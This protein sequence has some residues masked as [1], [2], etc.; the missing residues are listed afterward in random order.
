[1]L[2]YEQRG[3]ITVAIG[4]KHLDKRGYVRQSAMSEV[5]KYVGES[6]P[7]IKLIERMTNGLAPWLT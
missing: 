1:M 6:Y 4:T 7:Y 2:Q 3:D 5:N